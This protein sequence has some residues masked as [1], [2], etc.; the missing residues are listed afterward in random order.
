VL[1]SCDI[2]DLWVGG[3]R[4]R[5]GLQLAGQLWIQ[6]VVYSLSHTHTLLISYLNWA[7]DICRFC[8]I[9]I[10]SILR[11][12]CLGLGI[13]QF[14]GGNTR[15]KIMNIEVP[16]SKCTIYSIETIKKWHGF[17]K[18]WEQACQLIEAIA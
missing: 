17:G 14:L 4:N 3:A 8:N 2:S 9:V 10:T 6:I 13:G 18:I 12:T 15:S 5:P 11:C 7:F 1:T 16:F